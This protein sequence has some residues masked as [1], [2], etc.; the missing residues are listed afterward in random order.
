MLGGFT[1]HGLINYVRIVTFTFTLKCH[2]GKTHSHRPR[3]D[4]SWGAQ[5]AAHTH[6][7]THA[8]A[9]R[10]HKHRI[11]QKEEGGGGVKVVSEEAEGALSRSRT[12]PARMYRRWAAA[13]SPR[14]LAVRL[15]LGPPHRA[16]GRFK[17]P[18]PLAAPCAHLPLSGRLGFRFRNQHSVG[19]IVE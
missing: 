1:R 18:A 10:N 16:T 19:L 12:L 15:S 14:S 3:G 17:F 9:T 4:P 7:D 2:H 6:S 8:R 11:E 5:G 13:L